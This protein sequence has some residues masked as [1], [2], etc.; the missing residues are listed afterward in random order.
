MNN[1]KLA[2]YTKTTLRV[3][4]FKTN[5]VSAKDVHRISPL[6]GDTP[7]IV[8]WNVDE[9]DVDNVLRIETSW[10]LPGDIIQVLT[11]AGYL[12]E[13]LPD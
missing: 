4:V 7:G 13:E 3:L 1:I 9:H 8:R 11:N 12:C 5:L 10:L 6:M 2:S